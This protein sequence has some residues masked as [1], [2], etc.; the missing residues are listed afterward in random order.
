M[1]RSPVARNIGVSEGTSY[2]VTDYGSE[3]CVFESRRVH[4][5]ASRIYKG[6]RRLT[7]K[8]AWDTFYDGFVLMNKPRTGRTAGFITAE[9]ALG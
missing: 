3:G 2:R 8:A 1:A 5:S 4:A 6:R 9:G 7:S